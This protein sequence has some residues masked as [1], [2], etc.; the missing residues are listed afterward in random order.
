VSISVEGYQLDAENSRE[1]L[2][3]LAHRALDDF[4][5]TGVIV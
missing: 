1:R 4:G 2:R 3:E 5:L